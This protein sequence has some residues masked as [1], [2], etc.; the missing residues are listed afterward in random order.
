MCCCLGA[1]REHGNDQREDDHVPEDPSPERQRRS[2][3]AMKIVTSAAAGERENAPMMAAGAISTP[4]SAPM[5]PANPKASRA[6]ITGEMPTS[7]AARRLSAAAR[8]AYL[9]NVRSKKRW[10]QSSSRAAPWAS[11]A[12]SSSSSTRTW[13]TLTRWRRTSAAHRSRLRI[14]PW[15]CLTEGQRGRR[16]IERFAQRARP[17]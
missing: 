13:R 2:V 5:A 9:A 15:V 17:A 4:D 8:S 16:D 6:V 3:H 1:P 11:A 12:V 10:S 14:R 7:R